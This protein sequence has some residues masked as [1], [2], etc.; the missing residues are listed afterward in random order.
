MSST[1]TRPPSSPTPPDASPTSTLSSTPTRDAPSPAPTATPPSSSPKNSN[2]N[3]GDSGGQDQRDLQ[4]CGLQAN[5]HGSTVLMS[6]VTTP[7]TNRNE[8][9]VTRSLLPFSPARSAPGPSHEKSLVTRDIDSLQKLPEINITMSITTTPT[10]SASDS[11]PNARHRPPLRWLRH[12]TEPD[13]RTRSNVSPLRPLRCKSI[14]AAIRTGV[15]RV[16]I[17]T[18]TKHGSVRFGNPPTCARDRP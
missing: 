12:L 4:V 7:P 8:A 16:H 15:S 6:S 17:N 2:A 18:F 10:T 5:L 3:A 9:R 14:R 13:S 1:P 11:N